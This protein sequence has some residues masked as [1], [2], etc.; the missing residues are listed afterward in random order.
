M[1][2]VMKSSQVPIEGESIEN[3]VLIPLDGGRW[4]AFGVAVKFN[5]VAFFR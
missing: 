3:R 1:N 5:A 2:R 4:L